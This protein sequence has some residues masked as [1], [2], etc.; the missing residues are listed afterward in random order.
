MTEISTVASAEIRQQWR[1]VE[2]VVDQLA[3]NQRD[4]FLLTEI[5]GYTYRETAESMN[6]SISSVRQ[7][8]NRA[9]SKIRARADTGADSIIIPTPVLGA[10]SALNS[11][12]AQ[13]RSNMSDWVQPRVSEL[14]AWLGNVSQAGTDALLQNSYSLIIGLTIIALGAASPTPSIQQ[15]TVRVAP[16]SGIVMDQR[17]LASQHRSHSTGTQIDVTAPGPTRIDETMRKPKEATPQPSDVENVPGPDPRVTNRVPESVKSSYD[18]RETDFVGSPGTD[19]SPGSE[20]EEGSTDDQD[21]DPGGSYIFPGDPRAPD[22]CP[23]PPDPPDPPEQWASVSNGAKLAQEA[24]VSNEAKLAQESQVY[25]CNP[26]SVNDPDGQPDLP[27][28]D[29]VVVNANS[30]DGPL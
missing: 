6:L 27:V 19:Q 17:P 23:D 21:G 2:N 11:W 9:R 8:L 24:S 28:D 16:T 30:A 10:D 12:Q 18:D 13:L 7:L 1:E 22:P 25:V 15:D 26:E 5:R 29:D 4:A 14:Q 3:P 20:K